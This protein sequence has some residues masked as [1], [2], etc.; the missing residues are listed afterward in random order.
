M[1]KGRIA[2][3]LDALVDLAAP[4]Q[5]QA[6]NA[7][8]WRGSRR[9]CTN[10]TSVASLN[11]ARRSTEALGM[12]FRSYLVE[13]PVDLESVFAAMTRDDIGFLLLTAA[14]HIPPIG[15]RWRGSRLGTSSRQSRR[16]VNSCSRAA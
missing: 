7:P 8:K 1:K 3:A 5:A 6:Q 16:Y 4:D 9:A 12:D 13:R 2:A 15:G 10:S 14:I 11:E